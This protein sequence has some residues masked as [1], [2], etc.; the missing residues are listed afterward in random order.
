MPTVTN[1]QTISAM[2]VAVFNRAPDAEGLGFW[3][4]VFAA[5]A[6]D[7]VKAIAA[8]FTD[9][10]A[11]SE[12][13]DPLN[14]LAFVQAIYQ[15]V[16]G[17]PGDPGGVLYWQNVLASG[18]SRSDM[19]ASF[20]HGALT[21]D[22]DAL[23]ASGG[24]TDAE[25]TAAVARQ[26]VLTNKANVGLNFTA[27]LGA[28]SNLDPA[29]DTTT[30]AGL[31]SDPAYLA[32]QAAIRSVTDNP[33][34]AVDAIAFL[35]A[36]AASAD[37]IDYINTNAPP[38]ADTGG[39]VFVLTTAVDNIPGTAGNDTIYGF[40]QENVADG[41]TLNS[42]DVINGDGGTNDIL[43][44]TI[45][46]GA[47]D[48]LHLNMSNVEKMV[49][50]DY[51]G[52]TFY[53]EN[54]TGL[55][56][57]SIS[58]GTEG[59]YFDSGTYV[60]PNV[61]FHNTDQFFE[62]DLGVVA[63]IDNLNVVVDN[64]DA[65][66]YTYSD[67]ANSRANYKNANISSIGA[68]YNVD[69]DGVRSNYLYLGESQAV[70]TV[71]VTGT[72]NLEL[73]I[74]HWN[75][76]AG[77][78]GSVKTIN[79]AGLTAGLTI[80]DV[81]FKG[82]AGAV[83]TVIGGQGN[84]RFTDTSQDNA[85]NISYTTGTGNDWVDVA[86]GGA[87]NAYTV[88]TGAGDDTVVAGVNFAAGS[89]F[90]G[91]AGIDIINIT[92]GAVLTPAVAGTISGFETLDV[93]GGTGTYD[94]SLNNFTTAQVDEAINGALAGNVILNK[95][96]AGFNLDLMSEARTNANFDLTNV[97]FVNLADATGAND[98]VNINATLNDGNNDAAA[99]GN[100]VN[101]RVQVNGVENIN[102]DS[103][104]GLLDTGV[105]ANAYSTTF[106]VLEVNAVKTLTL[107]GD[108]D[109]VFTT[110]Q[111]VS[112]TLTAVN[113]SAS[114]GDITLDASAITSAIAYQ[115]SAG[116]D[117]Y[118]S[119]TAGN[120]IKGAGGNDQIT[121]TAGVI[122]DTLIYT[123]GSDVKFSDANADGKIDA[124]DMETVNGFVTTAAAVGHDILDISSFGF[125][126]YAK[127]AVD[128]GVVAPA[129]RLELGNFAM[130][131]ADF[132]ADA[133]GDRSAAFATEGAD[134]YVFIDADKNGDWNAATDIAVL[135][136][137]ATGLANTDFNF[138]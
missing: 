2:Y 47:D 22:L 13:Y 77:T 68:G 113:A 21:I 55:N 49:I 135:L 94:V 61:E 5:N 27:I 79:A 119:S 3:E 72:T 12:I 82:D 17:G 78:A 127:G 89:T 137:G 62:Q 32:S 84:D 99:D 54:V 102:I 1:K 100:I 35:N 29:T 130:T 132:F 4:N 88:D 117:T 138:G 109:I 116:V 76:P 80:E 90:A 6:D 46:D 44:V 85:L 15:N 60:I 8:G 52:Q 56:T 38:A 43:R 105:L 71:T 18:V 19:L 31:E 67:N 97:L 30:V 83:K 51:S 39:A 9:H 57:V 41:T 106:N 23:K 14:D 53:V 37:P 128:K 125:A 10:P 25:Y 91:G 75:A 93:S 115:G 104:V 58:D 123:A 50:Q 129:D 87:T 45:E 118:V 131:I 7:G 133:G 24:L 103:T 86:G 11:F 101:A 136:V 59:T 33:Q 16:L 95:A 66:V 120:S 26:N 108:S 34:T 134:T 40:V 65:E 126:G 73:E 114:T 107:T 92:D 42:G 69:G 111:N 122:Q 63:V 121:L 48:N 20:V 81:D 70:D 124:L 28:D 36:A 98:T 112:N 110:L 96:A 64:S 74:E